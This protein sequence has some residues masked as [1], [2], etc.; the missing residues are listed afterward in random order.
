MHSFDDGKICPSFTWLRLNLRGE[1]R[2]GSRNAGDY[3]PKR[4]SY[5]I[6]LAHARNG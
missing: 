5:Q 3:A 2:K 4:C 1:G 6:A